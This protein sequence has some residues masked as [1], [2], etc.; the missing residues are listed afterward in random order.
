MALKAGSVANFAGSLVDAMDKAM[1]KEWQAVKG[2]PLPE[3]GQDDRRLLFAA[4]SQGL[5]NFLKEH[6]DELMDNI[7]IQQ[8]NIG[9]PINYNVTQLELNLE[10]NS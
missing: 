4:I 2:V 5:F 7:T 10:S 3:Q 9:S 1:K 8:S 6:E